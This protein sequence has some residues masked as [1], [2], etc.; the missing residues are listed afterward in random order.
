MHMDS[1]VIMMLS[2]SAFLFALYGLA[3]WQ[4]RTRLKRKRQDRA[5]QPVVTGSAYVP[6]SDEMSEHRLARLVRIAGEAFGDRSRGL[7][8][9]AEP[10]QVFDGKAPAELADTDAGAERVETVLMRM[11]HG[12]NT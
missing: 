6:M 10:N 8:W 2:S 12:I 9:L 3:M 5:C 4:E 7:R 1:Y 11:M